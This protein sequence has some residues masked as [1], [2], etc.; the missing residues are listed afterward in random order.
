MLVSRKVTLKS[1]ITEDFRKQFS[2]QVQSM[3]SEVKVELDKLKASEQQLMLNTGSMDYNQIMQVKSQLERE[4][5]S[6]ETTVK[7]LEVRIEQV[8][9]MNDGDL[10]NQGLLDGHAEI[11]VGDNL[12]TKLAASEIVVKDGVVQSIIEG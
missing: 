4:K 1:V 8:S 6:R 11:K 10:F 12:D 3:I 2:T 9:K 5:T 7:E